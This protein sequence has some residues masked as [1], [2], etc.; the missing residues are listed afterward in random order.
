M[1]KKARRSLFEEGVRGSGYCPPLLVI[2][3]EARSSQLRR[4]GRLRGGL[5]GEGLDSRP[6]PLFVSFTYKCYREYLLV[7]FLVWDLINHVIDYII[8][9]I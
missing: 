7:G 6:I 2:P 8:N 1:G 4:C 3:S 5:V 9:L